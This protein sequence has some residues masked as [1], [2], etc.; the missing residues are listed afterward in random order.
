MIK[1]LINVFREPDAFNDDPLNWAYSQIG[2]GYLGMAMVTIITWVLIQI[3]GDYPDDLIIVASVIIAYFFFWELDFQGWRGWD[4]IEDTL[5][6]A[7]GAGLFW[8]IDM[9]EVIDRLAFWVVMTGSAILAG[10]A[11]RLKVE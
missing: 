6:V 10:V 8:I 5:F 1:R 3:H 7:A 11:R 4:T 9:S 2:H